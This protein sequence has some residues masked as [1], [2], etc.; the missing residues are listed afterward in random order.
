MSS[1][2][3]SRSALDRAIN[4][5]SSVDA[6]TQMRARREPRPTERAQYISDERRDRELQ[7]QKPK[8]KSSRPNQDQENRAPRDVGRTP[9]ICIPARRFEYSK[10]NALA[11]PDAANWQGASTQHPFHSTQ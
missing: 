4:S 1:R 11:E 3:P 9:V 10:N 7:R 2:A 5:P 8:A 6:G